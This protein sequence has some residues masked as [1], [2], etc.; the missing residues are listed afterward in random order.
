[1]KRQGQPTVQ[2][3]SPFPFQPLSGGLA[4]GRPLSSFCLLFPQ[5]P[6][7]PTAR[8]GLPALA[9]SALG[10]GTPAWGLEAVAFSGRSSG[11][12]LAE[13]QERGSPEV[14]GRL[15]GGAVS[16]RP[17]SPAQVGGSVHVCLAT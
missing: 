6:G 17:C 4:K 13:G 16:G 8:V 1:M 10:G 14:A 9:S 2:P 15:G 5:P 12:P 7:D 11:C 3:P